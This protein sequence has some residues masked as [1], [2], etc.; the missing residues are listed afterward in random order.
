MKKLFSALIAIASLIPLALPAVANFSAPYKHTANGKTAV[1][2]PGLTAG[3]KYTVMYL[4]A[5]TPKVLTLN[6]CGWAFLKNSATAEIADFTGPAS[7]GDAISGAAPTCNNGVSSPDS[8]VGAVIELPAAANT[9]SAG[10]W[11]RGGTAAGGITLNVIYGKYAKVTANDCGFAKITETATR[12]L[13]E[14]E[15][16]QAYNLGGGLNSGSFNLTNLPATNSPQ[17]CKAPF[18][19]APKVQYIPAAG[20]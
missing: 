4:T 10:Y 1:Y 18:T 17:I 6:A 16:S 19:G 9:L 20:F 12:S 7:K 8:P 11:V 5:S 3:Q 15:F 13:A 14:F 2:F